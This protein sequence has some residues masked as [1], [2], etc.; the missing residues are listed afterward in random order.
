MQNLWEWKNSQKQKADLNSVYDMNKK[1]K[2]LNEFLEF[3]FQEFISKAPPAFL[4]Q[5]LQSNM[6]KN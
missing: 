4:A 2:N 5:K 3:I 6:H 1:K